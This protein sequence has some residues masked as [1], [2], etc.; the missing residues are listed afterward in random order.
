[1]PGAKNATEIHVELKLSSAGRLS[2]LATGKENGASGKSVFSS[3][4]AIQHSVKAE[5]YINYTFPLTVINPGAAKNIEFTF[6]LFK[7]PVGQ[8]SNE[9]VVKIF[10]DS[11]VTNDD[12]SYFYEILLP[13]LN[14]APE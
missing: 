14:E 12:G 4:G 10:K 5:D 7:A 11:I 8:S 13:P 3:D 1:M 6:Y 9:D 2:A